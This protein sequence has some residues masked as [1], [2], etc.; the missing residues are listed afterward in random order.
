M[1]GVVRMGTEDTATSVG[2]SAGK[3]ETD[4]GIG[5]ILLPGTTG[6]PLIDS[7]IKAYKLKGMSR[8]LAA[9]AIRP[10][11]PLAHMCKILLFRAESPVPG[12]ELPARSRGGLDSGLV[13]YHFHPAGAPF[14]PEARRVERFAA[15]GTM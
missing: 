7:C 4:A 2:T 11:R 15:C 14:D 12:E 6:L 8:G 3:A 13:A 5:A 1:L 9:N 10:W